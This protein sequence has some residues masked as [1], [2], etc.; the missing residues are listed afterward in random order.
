MK[1]N[2]Y[3]LVLKVCLIAVLFTALLSNALFADGLNSK[4][5][6]SS[7]QKS[8]NPLILILTF[9]PSNYNGF[10]ISC[11]GG[12]DGIIDLTPSNGTAPY[13]YIWSN[14]AVDE[15]LNGLTAGTYTVTVTDFLGDT[16]TGS[17]AL[18][19]PTA[20]TINLDNIEVDSCG[21]VGDG[22][23]F[24]SVT[25]GVLNYGYVWS[26]ASISEDISGLAANTYTVT[27]T[28]AN[29]CIASNAFVVGEVPSLILS[30][31][32]VDVLCNGDA[33]GSIDLIVLGGTPNY[34]YTWSNGGVS[35]DIAG[36]IADTYTVTVTDG[37]ACTATTSAV[38][39]QPI[40]AL[41]LSTSP[42][43]VA[44]FGGNT[45]SIN[46]TVT[47]GTPNYTY[48]WSN[49]FTGE[50]PTALI[51]GTYTVTV[52]DNNSCTATTSAIVTQPAS[53]LGLSTSPTSVACFGG[54]TG[55][56]NL[57]VTGGTP[58]YTYLWSNGFTGEDPTALIA[59]TYTVT[60]TDN[61][62]C[63]ATT[64]AI[65]T[66]PASG[67]G[68]STSPTSVACFGGNT[69]SINLTVTGGTPFTPI[70]G[71]TDLRAKTRCINC[72]NVYSYRY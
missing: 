1:Q 15:D 39:N 19:E 55:S 34:N 49:G 16:Q 5:I 4:K 43:S 9:N 45:G 8:E 7:V 25:G 23:V 60:V 22:A 28:D 10:N 31:S 65:V 12:N 57:T 47:G 66:Q 71:V 72:R 46:L 59:G 30:T 61:N 26:N 64:S 35:Q 18:V 63:T 50:D 51:A 40:A 44:C 36:L 70:S 33:T 67:L 20:L 32:T 52:T 42:T 41:G 24:I 29:L 11:N 37:S 27:V 48:L 21:G 13:T 14:G 62:S 17:I 68:L 58:N 69:G 53:G 38:I 56:I 6:N 3:A 2:K 54:N